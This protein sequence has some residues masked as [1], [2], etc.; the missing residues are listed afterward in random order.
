ML[1]I[2]GRIALASF[3]V[4]ALL[5]LYQLNIYYGDYWSYKYCLVTFAAAISC[6][7]FMPYNGIIKRAA[8][9]GSFFGGSLILLFISNCPWNGFWIY[10]LYLTFFH[11][12][13]YMMTAYYNEHRLSLDSFL[14]NHSVEYQ[15]AALAAFI[16]FCIEV[17]FFPSFKCIKIFNFIGLILVTSGELIRKLAMITAGSNFSHIVQDQKNSGHELVTHGI[18]KFSR[19]PSYVGWFYWSIGEFLPNWYKSI[20]PEVFCEEDVLNNFAN[21]TGKHLCWTLYDKCFLV[22]FAKF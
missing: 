17:Y 7:F 8:L 13:E 11:F 1:C 22:T 21:F 5:A 10:I 20:L 3:T 2:E 18:Y 12:S 16:E 4:F 6:T 15:I 9:L 19:H 14:L